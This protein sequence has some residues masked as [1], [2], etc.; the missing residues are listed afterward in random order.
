M[1]DEASLRGETRVAIAQ[2]K[3]AFWIQFKNPRPGDEAV[4]S[5]Y[6]R[7]IKGDD[8]T[9]EEHP[10]AVQIFKDSDL[11]CGGSLISM[12]HVL[13]AAHCFMKGNNAVSPSHFTIIAGSEYFNRGG[14]EVSV[15][16]IVI[17]DSYDPSTEDCD[18]AVVVLSSILIQ[19]DQIKSIDI[20][21]QGYSLPENT[22]VTF[23]GWGWTNASAYSPSNILQAVTVPTVNRTI[24]A[25][26]YAEKNLSNGQPS[27][28]TDNMFCAGLLNVKTHARATVVGPRFSIRL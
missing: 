21:K 4:N 22:S 25:K 17:H 24:C 20:P 28:V 3:E 14:T 7:I 1:P 8:T 10:Y 27:V 2:A 18:I 6:Q 11:V 15:S 23:A 5:L 16:M 9:I 13:S 12:R 19:S 26:H